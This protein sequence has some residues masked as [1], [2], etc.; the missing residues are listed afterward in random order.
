[1][2][3]AVT[4]MAGLACGMLGMLATAKL[5]KEETLL[6]AWIRFIKRFQT[7]LKTRRL[8]ICEALQACLGEHPLIDIQL[9]RALRL[10]AENPSL[11]IAEAYQQICTETDSLYVTLFQGIS[12]GTLEK[13]LAALE[14][15]LLSFVAAYEKAKAAYEKNGRLFQNLGWLG[16]LALVLLLI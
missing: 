16:G 13:R 12:E 10:M 8:P 5:R 15:S 11:T 9:N 3:L 2:A 14:M 6:F 7:T 4:L 1:L